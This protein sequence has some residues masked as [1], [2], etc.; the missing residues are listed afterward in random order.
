MCSNSRYSWEHF[1]A[2]DYTEATVEWEQWAVEDS[3]SDTGE[4]M[5]LRAVRGLRKRLLVITLNCWHHRIFNLEVKCRVCEERV[6]RN[7]AT[8]NVIIW[9]LRI[10]KS[11][12]LKFVKNSWILEYFKIRKFRVLNLWWWVIRVISIS[13]RRPSDCLS[14]AVRGTMA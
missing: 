5:K 14:K 12:V 13:I 11:T 9:I 10:L 4:D 1:S 2:I 3:D 6:C 8:I 7:L